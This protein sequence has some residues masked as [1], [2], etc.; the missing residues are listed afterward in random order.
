LNISFKMKRKTMKINMANNET[1]SKFGPSG[2]LIKR[3]EI[4]DIANEIIINPISS[5]YF[6]MFLNIT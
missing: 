4:R 3:N 1:I 6:F 2:S 5:A